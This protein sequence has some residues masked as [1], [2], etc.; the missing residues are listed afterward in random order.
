MITSPFFQIVPVFPS[1]VAFQTHEAQHMYPLFPTLPHFLRL[2][3]KK[4]Y[5]HIPVS[6]FFFFFFFFLWETKTSQSTG[7]FVTLVRFLLHLLTWCAIFIFCCA[8]FFFSSF[9]F[10]FPDQLHHFK[11]PVC[12]LI[13]SQSSYNYTNNNTLDCLSM[14]IYMCDRQVS[15]DSSACADVAIEWTDW[16]IWSWRNVPVRL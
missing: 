8:S 15:F 16:Y 4:K 10:L 1:V 11:L 14:V 9:F 6:T 12:L 7:G 2:I 3:E 13:L 5:I